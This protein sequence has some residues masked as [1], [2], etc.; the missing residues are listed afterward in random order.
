M[1]WSLLQLVAF[2]SVAVADVPSDCPAYDQYAAQQ[3]EPLS[4]G[5]YK[6]PFQRPDQRCRSYV[7]P[8]V[9]KTIKKAK[10]KIKDPDL[11][12]LFVNTWPNTVDTTVLWRGR[13][14]DNSDEEVKSF[15]S[16]E[17]MLPQVTSRAH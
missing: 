9:E 5:K 15:P 16:N 8:E 10:C 6:Y 17:H 4:T 12:R 14:M 7:V 3:H 13:A 1:K 2:A 11:Y